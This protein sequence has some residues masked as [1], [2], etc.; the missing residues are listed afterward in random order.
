MSIFTFPGELRWNEARLAVEF[1]IELGE[2]QALV[3]VPQRVVH[4]LI[5]RRPSPE[6]CVAYLYEARM[7]FERIA[8]AKIVARDLGEDANIHITGRDVARAKER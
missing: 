5:G 8:E 7:Q 1:D 2:Y 4:D 6:E 3:F